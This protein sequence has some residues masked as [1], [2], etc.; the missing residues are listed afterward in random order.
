[1]QDFFEFSLGARVLY[2]MGLASE[3]GQVISNA[4]PQRRAFIVADKGVVQAGLLEPI[5]AG[6]APIELVGIFDDVP[7]NSSV[8]KVARRRLN[9]LD[10]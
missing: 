6:L 5:R 10:V 1:M 3:L 7:A 4:L 8:A 2:Q 9:W